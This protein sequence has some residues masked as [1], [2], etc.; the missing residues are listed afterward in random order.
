MSLIRRRKGDFH[1]L[2]FEMDLREY[3]KTLS[4]I[5]DIT[6]SIKESLTDEDDS[7]FLKTL[8][9]GTISAGGTDVVSVSVEWLTTEYSQF[10]VGKKYLAG[11]FA[12]FTGDPVADENVD[13]TW[14][15][16][17]Y[18]DFLHS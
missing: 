12:T 7:L 11:L 5:A 1:D 4:D 3:G 6:F 15:I 10:K 18:Q 8:G 9:A 2:E 16:E 14:E 17:I 13:T